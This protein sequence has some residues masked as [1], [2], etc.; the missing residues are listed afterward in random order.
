MSF[1]ALSIAIKLLGLLVIKEAS[2]DGGDP[3][4]CWAANFL[5][6]QLSL[7]TNWLKKASIE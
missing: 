7:I 6:G 5:T 2:F 3:L 1:G 4:I